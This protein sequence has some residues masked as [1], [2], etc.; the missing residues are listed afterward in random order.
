[1]EL[2]YRT[3]A[4]IRSLNSLD[5]VTIKE[6]VGDNQYIASYK[7]SNCMA[8]FN[9]FTGTFF[10]DDIYGALPTMS[11]NEWENAVQQLRYQYDA[12]QKELNEYRKLGSVASLKALRKQHNK[13]QKLIDQATKAV[14]WAGMSSFAG[15]CAF[16]AYSVATQLF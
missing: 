14:I 12:N 11:E 4:T 3:E 16:V 13:K 9:P 1:M 8:I 7:G 10:V 6:Q 15:M 2:N 5:K